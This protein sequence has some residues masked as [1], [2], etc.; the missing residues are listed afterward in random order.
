M[1]HLAAAIVGLAL[2]A[3]AAVPGQPAPRKPAALAKPAKP[4]DLPMPG[5]ERLKVPVE[6][7]LPP[8]PPTQRPPPV[9]APAARAAA[10]GAVPSPSDAEIVAAAS[11]EIA[12]S[13]PGF[14]LVQQKCGR[15]HPMERA[16]EAGFAPSDWEPYIKRKLRRHGAGI[17]AA[18]AEEIVRFLSTWSKQRSER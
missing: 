16:I 1:T 17:S 5:D 8:R 14:T 3:P 12:D 4:T 11:G 15:C 2:A 7:V 9:P 18:Q 10:S 6:I 13:R